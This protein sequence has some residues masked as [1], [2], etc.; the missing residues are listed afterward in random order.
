MPSLVLNQDKNAAHED[1]SYHP[2]K[3]QVTNP[4]PLPLSCQ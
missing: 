4:L 1:S 3:G 2:E